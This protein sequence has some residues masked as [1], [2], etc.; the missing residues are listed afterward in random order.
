MS[1]SM[2]LKF[3]VLH[4]VNW[5]L[6]YKVLRG[7]G[8][9]LLELLMETMAWPDLRCILSVAKVQPSLE[10]SVLPQ[11]LLPSTV[12]ECRQLI[13]VIA[14]FF[15]ASLTHSIYQECSTS[16]SRGQY[17][18]KNGSGANLILVPWWDVPEW[19]L[20][21]TL[22]NLRWKRNFILGKCTCK[23]TTA[24]MGSSEGVKENNH[25]ASLLNGSYEY[26]RSNFLK[27]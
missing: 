16:Y 6:R 23:S 9:R 17:N 19:T 3:S 24:N 1:N 21:Y 2:H 13:V 4:N 18:V 15:F 27:P 11:S 25:W 10:G 7:G 26:A 8:V 5:T 12:P 22:S 20:N 14:R